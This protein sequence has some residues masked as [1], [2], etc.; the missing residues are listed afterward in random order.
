MRLVFLMAVLTTVTH[1]SAQ[2]P[3]DDFFLPNESI[4]RMG[5]GGPPD[6]CTITG[7]NR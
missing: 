1:L 4:V 2:D 6:S 7:I 5:S 3:G